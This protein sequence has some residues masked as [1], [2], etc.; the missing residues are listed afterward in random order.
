MAPGQ[1]DGG[2]GTHSGTDWQL[3]VA[4]DGGS[5][6]QRTNSIATCFGC[7]THRAMEDP[8]RFDVWA[9]VTSPYPSTAG[10]WLQE[11]RPELSLLEAKRI[12][13]RSVAASEPVLLLESWA[14]SQA[15]GFRDSPPSWLT[16]VALTQGGLPR[17]RR[18]HF[19]AIHRLHYAGCLGCHVC[20]HFHEP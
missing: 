19:C 1:S 4:Q 2:A 7:Y 13:A 16:D 14:W 3:R 11:L 9:R 8:T 18:G 5:D 20:N 17:H 15:R 12:L 10:A 6:Y